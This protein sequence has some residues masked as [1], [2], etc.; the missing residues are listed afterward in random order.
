MLTAWH[1]SVLVHRQAQC[2]LN[3]GPVY[4]R[5]TGESINSLVPEGSGCVFKNTNFN[6]VSL[7]H[8]DWWRPKH[9]KVIKWKHFPRYW[10]F[11]RGIHRS[12]VDSPHKSQ[13]R[14][15]LMF[16]LICAWT[17][18]WANNRGDRD[19]RRHRPHCDVTVMVDATRHYWWQIDIVSGNGLVP[20]CNK[21]LPEPMLTQLYVAIQLQCP[22]M[23]KAINIEITP[24]GSIHFSL[25][26]NWLPSAN[27]CT[28][29]M[30]WL[31]YQ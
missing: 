29:S 5:D 8:C 18:G 3:S 4:I 26:D 22:T 21:P 15:A 11:V 7:V 19:L 16:S 24:C 31:A 12:P 9:D 10:P 23:S 13:W 30:T 20:P 28:I 1:C 2:W 25:L 27:I 14:G 17:N 6:F